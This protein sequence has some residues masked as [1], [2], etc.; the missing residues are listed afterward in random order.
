MP[1]DTVRHFRAALDEIQ[2]YVA[3]IMASDDASVREQHFIHVNRKVTELHNFINRAESNLGHKQ[4]E[5]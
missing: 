1:L 3:R 2:V 4:E 5:E